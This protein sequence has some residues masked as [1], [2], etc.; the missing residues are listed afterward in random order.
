[1]AWSIAAAGLIAAVGIGLS[2]YADHPIE[3][4]PPP[5]LETLPPSAVAQGVPNPRTIV[6]NTTFEPSRSKTVVGICPDGTRTISGGYTTEP[7]S[8]RLVL[9]KSA[10]AGPDWMVTVRSRSARLNWRLTVFVLCAAA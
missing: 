1:L 6:T 7:L 5:Q 2:V 3:P 8:P 4:S 9:A 10:P